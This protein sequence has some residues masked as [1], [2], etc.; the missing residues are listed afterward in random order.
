MTWGRR[1]GARERTHVWVQTHANTS[2]PCVGLR[3]IAGHDYNE[4]A[5]HHRTYFGARGDVGELAL[6]EGQDEGEDGEEA[7]EADLDGVCAE[8]GKRGG[9]D[10]SARV[11][12]HFGVLEGVLGGTSP[13]QKASAAGSAGRARTAS[14]RG[15]D[16]AVARGGGLPLDGLIP[17]D[18]GR[19]ELGEALQTEQSKSGSGVISWAPGSVAK[20]VARVRRD[21]DGTKSR[22]QAVVAWRG[23][24]GTAPPVRRMPT[25]ARARG[26]RPCSKNRTVPVARGRGHV[27]S[28]GP[29]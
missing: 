8:V 16:G 21:D 13:R 11:P 18:R 6:E 17:V 14:A 10:A 22:A 9:G 25:C 27:Q 3:D 2:S 12:P 19:V 29:G 4:H 26:K 1:R 28:S 7:A 15:H 24:A 23:A 20:V 5:G